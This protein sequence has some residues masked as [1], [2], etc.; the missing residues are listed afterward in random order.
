MTY[1]ERIKKLPFEIAVSIDQF[2]NVLLLG[3]HDETLSARAWRNYR[4]E[5]LFGKIFKPLIDA[6]FFWQDTKGLGHCQQAFIRE[7]AKFYLPKEY[8]ED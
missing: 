3:S 6:L 2:L 1:W 8:H 4:D 5:K 7:K